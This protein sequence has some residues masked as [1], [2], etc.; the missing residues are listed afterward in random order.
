MDLIVKLALN[1]QKIVILQT[2]HTASGTM[3]S[4]KAVFEFDEIWD[5]YPN[6]L[7]L[8]HWTTTSPVTRRSSIVQYSKEVIGNECY[9][10]KDVM[11]TKGTI[12]ISLIGTDGDK[13]LSSE[14]TNYNITTG[15]VDEGAIPGGPDEELWAKILSAYEEFVAQVNEFGFDARYALLDHNHDDKY[16]L[17]DHTH[18]DKLSVSSHLT[19]SEIDQIIDGTYVEAGGDEPV[20]EGE[21]IDLETL[22]GIFQ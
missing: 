22:N 16:A 5:T 11:S 3:N 15:A 1:N 9:L 7:A 13:I 10:P 8:F 4:V 12:F 21:P 18:T 19:E 14:I 6:K 17:I 2:N 20:V